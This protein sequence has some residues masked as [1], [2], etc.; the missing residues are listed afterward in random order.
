MRLQYILSKICMVDHF[1]TIEFKGIYPCIKFI[2]SRFIY[3]KLCRGKICE[4]KKNMDTIH[5]YVEYNAYR[6]YIIYYSL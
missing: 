3:T 2:F 1:I 4:K 5:S 6:F